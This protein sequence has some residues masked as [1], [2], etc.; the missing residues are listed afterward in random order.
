MR[1][2]LILHGWEGSG[3]GHWQTWLA[4]RLRGNGEHVAY[5]DLPDADAPLLEPWLEALEGELDA[6]H[7]DI[8][9]LC[10]SLACLLWL[11]HL[12]RGGAQAARLLL[13]APPAEQPPLASFFPVPFP[14]VE[15][16]AR[17]AYSDADSFCPEG[18][19]ELY[20]KPL[21][22]PVDLLPGAGH[23]NT[24]AG[25]GVWP[26]VEAW[27]VGQRDSVAG[28]GAKNGSDT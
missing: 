27:A 19:D 5:P 26:D 6:L 17:L 25:Y 21:G 12:D 28:S 13:V 11:H 1:S 18:A 8:T 2:F 15:G 23:V 3:P 4:G 20:G 7:G 16:D 22:L 9:V 14:R 24:D 10:H